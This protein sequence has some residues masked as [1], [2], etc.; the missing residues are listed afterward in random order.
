[1]NENTVW[2]DSQDYG[3]KSYAPPK[4]RYFTKQPDSQVKLSLFSEYLPSYSP[5]IPAHAENA[6]IIWMLT[7]IAAPLFHTTESTSSLAR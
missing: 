1:M 2:T 4:S 7:R 5:V 3:A 6:S